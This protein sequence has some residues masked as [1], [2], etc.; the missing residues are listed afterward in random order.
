[1]QTYLTRRRGSQGD[2]GV[3]R[4]GFAPRETVLFDVRMRPADKRYR[5]PPSLTFAVFFGVRYF[6]YQSNMR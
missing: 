4:D 5:D 2:P 1:M 3:L 6:A